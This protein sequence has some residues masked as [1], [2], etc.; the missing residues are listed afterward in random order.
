MKTM[1]LNMRSTYGVETVDEL[2]R[3]DFETGK[4]FRKELQRL[5]YEYRLAGMP[6]YI[7]SRCTNEWKQK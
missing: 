4:E 7:S 1:Y 5:A 3:A 6:V 2:S